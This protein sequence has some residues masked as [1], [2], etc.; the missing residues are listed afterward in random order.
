GEVRLGPRLAGAGL[1]ARRLRRCR[2][3]LAVD[4]GAGRRQDLLCVLEL[5]GAHPPDPGGSALEEPL[6]GGAR[7]P[8][9]EGRIG[10]ESLRGPLM[11]GV[12]SPRLLG[13]VGV[14]LPDAGITSREG[15]A[16]IVGEEKRGRAADHRAGNPP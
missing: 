14:W 7:L 11:A 4:R 9:D 8:T 3:A 12:L 6:A 10:P 15:G 2:S 1:G 13:D 5:A 16:G